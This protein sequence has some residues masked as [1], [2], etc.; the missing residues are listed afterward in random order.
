M[1]DFTIRHA[2]NNNKSLDDVMR[3]LYKEYY[4]RKQSG[5]SDA[6]FQQACETV[7]GTSLTNIFEYV[8]TTKE[9]DYNKYLDYAGLNMNITPINT[10]TVNIVS[11]ISKRNFQIVPANNPDELQKKFLNHGRVSSIKHLPQ[12]SFS[13][14]VSRMNTL[15]KIFLYVCSSS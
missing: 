15:S 9:I 11:E 5:F 13:L 1:L 3:L 10:E 14:R 7:A 12:V 4:Q 2:T 6:E 8:T